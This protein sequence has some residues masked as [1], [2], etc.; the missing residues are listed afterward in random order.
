MQRFLD[1]YWD[2]EPKVFHPDSNLVKRLLAAYAE[3]TGE[4][5]QPVV[6]GGATYAKRLPNS[7]AFGKGQTVVRIEMSNAASTDTTIL[8]KLAQAAYARMP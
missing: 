7:I 6:A 2:D 1:G 3:A 4:S 5:A 8:E